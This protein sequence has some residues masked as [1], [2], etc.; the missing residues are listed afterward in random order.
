MKFVERVSKEVMIID[1]SMGALL[2][3]EGLPAGYAPDLWNL[4]KP[5]V[6]VNVHKRYVDAG[7]QI[8]ITNTF[9]ACVPRL[10]EYGRHGDLKAINRAAVE[11]ARRGAD[12]RA[13]VAGGMGPSGRLVFPVGDLA[14][15]DAITIFRQQASALVEAGTDILIIETMFDLMEMK[16]AIIAC[17]EVRKNTPL[18]ASMTY[19]AGGVTD[20]GTGPEAAA[21]VMEGLGVD[22]I[23]VNCSTGPAEMLEV[24]G[25]IAEVSSLP[26]MVEPNAGL[27]TIKGGI[28]SYLAS[29]DEIA[30]YSEKFVEL[31]AN[32]IGGCCGTRPE[33]IQKISALV[34]G[35]PVL[36]RR[37]RGGVGISSRSSALWIGEGKPFVKIGEKIN[38]TGRK[39]FAQS[40][41]DG[42][43]DLILLE[44]RKQEE[45]GASALDVNVGVPLTDEP[46]MMAKA[47]TALQ[48][49]TR[50]PLVIDSSNNNALATG[51]SVYA[52]RA[53]VNSVNA[54][55]EK[56]EAILPL[57]KRMGAAV[58]ALTAGEDVPESAQ[59]RFEYAK[60]I[61]DRAL[62]LGLRREDIVFDCLSVVVSAMQEGAAQTLITIRRIR[63][64]LGCATTVG[65]SNTSFGLPDRQAINNGFLAMCMAEGLDAAIVNPYD[66]W[67]HKTS[68]AASLFTRRD[69]GC[70]R[71][72]EEAGK[73][74][75][76]VS[77][78]QSKIIA[79]SASAGGESPV[80][81]H[82]I[83]NAVVEGE[84]DSVMALVKTALAGGEKPMDIFFNHLT[85]AIRRV[86]DLFAERKKFIPHLVASA[87]TMKK[88]MEILEP[89]LA[90]ERKGKNAGTI[91]FATVKGDVHDIGKNVC[92][93]ML[94]N[95]GYKVVDLGR[96]VPLDD[97]LR[98]AEENNADIL[99]LSAL[100]TTTMIQMPLVVEEVKKRNL[101]YR[102]MVGGAVVTKSFAQE[103]GADGYGRDV[104][105]IPALAEKLM[106]AMAK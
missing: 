58:I 57:I 6:I 10:E 3:G 4:E 35:K 101:P 104:S 7:A 79:P 52:G 14:F 75:Q 41:K 54:E 43:T 36:A 1:G 46:K 55:A 32:I 100:M 49:V 60:R 51:L 50:L 40:V 8:V 103:I 27:P 34:K 78:P 83:F 66:E 61:L 48:N 102:I 56:M 17:N 22:V 62:A 44:A 24:V 86:G 81:H 26:I 70:K 69:V 94:Q 15:E 2:Q 80:K 85:P 45:A 42:D 106:K 30:S 33:Y 25:R 47:V 28:T 23:G 95:Y 89:L 99:A 65:L 96:N 29:M 92:C 21:V 12:G 53:L 11:N 90:A 97:I 13:L 105:E 88:A 71:Y 67:I 59:K 76:S 38:P 74:V 68:S 63:E 77:E 91:I 18:I 9:G 73:W 82:P 16:A 39:K 64:E 93:I 5:D 19:A 72:M 98:S 31:G 20:T 87:D 84:K 37:G